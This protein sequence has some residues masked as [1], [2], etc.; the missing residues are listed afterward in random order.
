M[1]KMRDSEIGGKGRFP[2]TRID[3]VNSRGELIP[4]ELSA[5][6]I[7]EGDEEL[8]HDGDF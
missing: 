2:C 3:I 5:A 7:Y 6:I 1:K 8:G 4:I